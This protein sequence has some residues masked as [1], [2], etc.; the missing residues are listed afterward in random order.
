M[1]IYSNVYEETDKETANIFEKLVN[2]I[3][4][5]NSDQIQK[6]YKKPLDSIIEMC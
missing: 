6:K 3:A 5:P 1:N 4:W 2:Q